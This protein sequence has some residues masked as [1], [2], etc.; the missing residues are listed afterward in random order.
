VVGTIVKAQAQDLADRATDR[1]FGLQA[2]ELEGSPAAIDDP[3]VRVAGEERGVGSRVVV[4]EQLEEVGEAAFVATPRLPAEAGVAI[5][6][7]RAV[8]AMRADE[9]MLARHRRR[10][11]EGHA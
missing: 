6:P 10:R 9:V 2:R 7:H 5:G 1:L 3:P 11:I 8:A 4:V